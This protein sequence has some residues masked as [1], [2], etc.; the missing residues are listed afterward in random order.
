MKK[1]LLLFG[2]L[3]VAAL[4]VTL[5]IESP[6]DQEGAYQPRATTIQSN[7]EYQSS[8]YGYME[9][10]HMLKGDFTQEEYMRISQD[11][12]NSN[13]YDRATIAWNDQ[14]PDNVGG[15]TRAIVIDV[16]DIN[17][18][19]AGSVSGGLFESKNRGN[20]WTKVD[21][22]SDNLA[23][24]SMC[25]TADG[26][27]YIATG[28]E[29][30]GTNHSGTDSGKEGDGLYKRETNGTFTQID[31][32]Y[33]YIN[34]VV[35]DDTHNKVWY[36]TKNG[37][38]SY[39]NGTITDGAPGIGS[40]ACRSLDI[41]PDGSI[42]VCGISSYR[43]NLSVNGG[44]SF[45]DVSDAGVTSNP[46]PSGV[47]RC[48]YSISDTLGDNGNYYIYASQS[49][50][51]GLLDGV[52]M[53]DDNGNNWTEIAPENNG[54]PGSFAPFQSG[55]TNGG[56]GWYDHIIKAGYKN[57]EKVFLGGIDVYNWSTTGNWTQLTQWFLHPTNSNYAHADQHEMVFDKEGRLYL[58][59]DGG[60]QISDDGGQT[61][62][63]ANRGYAVTQFYAIGASA[64]GDVIGGAQDNGT[65]AN[66][67]DNHT[68]REFDEVGGGDG[69]TCELSFINRDIQLTSVYY[70]AVRRSGDRGATSG[71]FTPSEFTTQGGGDIL[72]CDPGSLTAGCG[73]F[74]TQFKLWENPNDLNSEDS[75]TFIPSQAYAANDTVIVPSATSGVFI[76][77]ITP[78]NV[79]YD[80]T[81]FFT[82]SETTS[83]SIVTTDNP[84]N[85]Y[86]LMQFNYEL[87][88]CTHPLAAGDSVH[89]IGI[90]TIIV[91][92]TSLQDHYYGTNAQRPGKKLD[93]GSE[94]EF[95]GVA[96]DT[97]RV[98]DPYQS[99]FAIGLGG[100]DGI[101]MTRNALRFSSPS[102]EWFRV[103]NSALGTITA[104]EYS[105]D[106]NN[107]FVGTS[108]GQLW[109]LSNFGDVYSPAKE[110]Y[111]NGTDTIRADTL[112]DVTATGTV[113]TTF[114]Q[115]GNFSNVV[116]DIAVES[117]V[118]HIVV[119]LGSVG[120]GTNK[121]YESTNAS[122]A[123]PAFTV[124]SSGSVFSGGM[125][126][127]SAVIDRDDPNTILVGTEF[128]VL[129]TEDGGSN[130]ETC[131]GDFG[132]VAV[133]DMIQNWRD[134]DDGCFRP[135]EIYIGTHGRGIWS[136]EAY[137]G[138]PTDQ[139]NLET[140]KFIPN[141]NVYPNPLNNVGNI[142]FSLE[143]DS[144]V[145][146]QIF[147]LSGQLVNE[148]T[149][150]NM[151][152]GNNTITFGA[153]NLP[154]GT[155][156]IRLT[157]GDKVETSKFIKH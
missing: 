107:L 54:N 118:D 141:I 98:Q 142:G 71:G 4:A 157:A 9:Y 95:Y 56:Q 62:F 123:S 30:E 32:G 39:E 156:I 2:T 21:A 86:N 79:V 146:V 129:I 40:G 119:T 73:P 115:I 76:D 60:V 44:T 81:V 27:L 127:Y 116:T 136:T 88:S 70:G 96:W 65:Q 17:H 55:G 84:A 144:D 36:A 1:S 5:L 29:R 42:I 22:F 130:W 13:A 37:L 77:Y 93:M 8:A 12:S 143:S 23:I 110:D 137:L 109:R 72:G 66:Y 3:S 61:F 35:C 80:D 20:Y 132:K 155:Y 102:D 154:K 82:S 7:G 131:N 6:K 117:D 45:I 139:D 100:G 134:Y 10:L 101:W 69:F 25:M 151:S 152:S 104:M 15:R 67:H 105:R 153:D 112:I 99:W 125:P 150:T 147:N 26:T 53:S 75:I 145:Y 113:Q 16:N 91:A 120:G 49:D 89:L 87:I 11:W 51:S 58:G 121:V 63:P 85:D 28:H 43:T 24:S 111:W 74:Y 97:L 138:L 124:I 34:E 48:E 149:E 38:K 18:L 106:G 135:G 52:Y 148:I 90:D 14:G 133:F 47:N 78:T 64:H 126:C 140:G 114:S 57:P 92:S 103:N 122:G 128:G 68:W 31:S 33:D 108:S 46:I 19:Y 83:D 50:G 94:T 59:N 41:S